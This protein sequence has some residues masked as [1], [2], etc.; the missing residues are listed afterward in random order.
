MNLDALDKRILSVLQ[1]DASKPAEQIGD[2]IGLSRNACWRRI[3]RLEEEGVIARRV[4]LVDPDELNLGL[5][6]FMAIRT[7]S[8][9]AAWL[10]TF[11]QA[12]RDIPEITGVY[13]MSGETDYLLRAS[14]P[15][16]K[17]Y[18]GLYQRIIARIELEDVSSSF[19]M[20]T[21]KETTELPLNY[22]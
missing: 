22:L 12:V 13:R 2:E 1:R 4:A 7:R 17:A 18:D 9:T 19:V 3:K 6:V 14:V 8:H 11:K 10:E 21:I 20:E 16:M 5:T 15:D